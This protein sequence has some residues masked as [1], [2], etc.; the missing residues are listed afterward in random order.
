MADGAAP[1]EARPGAAVS[2]FM[3]QYLAAKTSHPDAMLF[4]RMGDF[5]ELF[6]DDA[7]NAAA[8]LG[9]TLTKRGQYLGEDIKMAGV[10]VHAADGY[11][12]RLIRAGFKV[13]V[14]E[15]MEDPAEARKRG[16]KSIVRRDVVRVV[17]PGT[18]TEDS[19][20]EARAA[21]RLAAAAIDGQGAALAWADV[22]TGACG[23]API[24]AA[25]LNDEIAALSP[26]ELLIADHEL[27]RVSGAASACGAALTPRPRQKADARA[28]AR[29]A[30]ALYE[31]A[32]LDAFG[33]FTEVELSALGL[34]LDYIELT[35][36]GLAPRLAP[37]QRSAA[38]AFMA[39]DQATRASLELER[40]QRGAREGSLLA[41]IDRTLTAAGGRL[42]AERLARPSTEA[43]EILR[44][45]DSIEHFVRDNAAREAVRNEVRGAP[46]LARALQRLSL[47]RGGPRDLAAIRDGLAA[48]G[49][50]AARCGALGD[51]PEELRACCAALSLP[52]HAALNALAV[53]L[54]RALGAELGLL[55]R[56]GGFIATGF[57]EALD[58]VRTLRDDSRQVIAALQTKYQEQ[59]GVAALKLRHNA[60]LGYHID[61]TPKQAEAL[62]QPPLSSIFIHRQTLAG[63]VRFTTTELV[64]L[65]ARIARAGAEALARELDLFRSF[66]ERATAEEA[67]IRAAAAALATLDVAT[68]AAE[69]AVESDGARPEI[70]SSLALIAE[71][72][73]HP[74]VEQA[75]RKAGGVFTANDIRLD[76]AGESG[77]RL[78]FVTGPNM[79]G[80]ST[81]LRQTALLAIIAQAGLYVPA[82]RLRLGLADR[83]FSRVGA[84]DDLAAGR[85]TF[86]AEMVETAAILHQ[87]G[88]RALVILD[89]I[90]RGTATFDGLAIAWA[91]A[92]H[93]HEING[94]RAMFATHYHE[95]T[96]L[97]DRL[98][99]AANASLRAKE[100]KGDLVFLHEVQPGAA[101]RSYGIQVAKLAGLPRSAVERAKAV[102][103]KLEAGRGGRH[104]GLVEELPLFAGAPPAP[105]P[106]SAVEEALTGVDPEA[107]SP[108]DA[109]ALVFRLKALLDGDE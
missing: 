76:G 14:C 77:A 13:A 97:A 38:G 27:A 31:V 86:M 42:L 54:G 9:I 88:P 51:L 83:V 71:G 64:E 19:L 34:L 11:L 108:R 5:Y 52:N 80:K 72:V 26:A 107:L 59:S 105:P 1:E 74:V 60:V 18:L 75:V 43:G 79:A 15:Q 91:A 96:S 7:V 44:R 73:R 78:L 103:A 58:R 100:W 35:Q 6:F 101:D 81:Y 29:R 66:C 65:D 30:K 28:G 8:A 48:G 69:W 70:D 45:L 47:G 4:F 46:D 10:P 57:D 56:D 94:C 85:S 25:R 40:T 12:A 36:A 32:A 82:K 61:C 55:A 98:S 53:E 63:S 102:L 62:L 99:A 39:I 22:S 90:G 41:A 109:L 49:R 2:P 37:P 21:N 33:D 67:A 3:A 24:P 23:V 17:T 87:A 92:E 50:G 106:G 84:A 89:E 68:G 16:S 104:S 20:L 93:L 95:L